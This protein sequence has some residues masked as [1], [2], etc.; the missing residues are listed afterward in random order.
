MLVLSFLSLEPTRIVNRPEDTQIVSGTTAQ[1]VCQAEY[2][3]SLQ[4]SFEVL[5]RKDGQDIPPP[6][7]E[8][9]R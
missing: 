3:E 2:D 6:F 4:G 8:N 9:S 7:E 5:W 1:L